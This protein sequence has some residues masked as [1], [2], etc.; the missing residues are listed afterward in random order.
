MAEF[1]DKV[2]AAFD[3]EFERTRPRPGLRRRVI[4]NAVATPRTQQGLRAW[5]TP[6]RLATL[7]AAAVLVLVI[8]TGVRLATQ[9]PPIAKT[10]PTPSAAQLAFG[11]LPPPGLHPPNGLGGGGGGA[12]T[13]V[14]YFGPATLTWSGQ[15]PTVPSSAP[16]YRFGLPTIADE[17]AF[18][19]RLGA[20]LLSAASGKGPRSYQRPDGYT[21]DIGDDAVAGELT[22]VMNRE[23]GAKPRQPLTEAA[24]RAAA[25]AELTRLGLTPSWNLT[26]QISQ[27]TP[28]GQSAPIFVVQYQRLIQVST[29]VTA[30]EVDGDGD[31]A[32][33]QVM[34]DPGGRVIR[35]A[36][37]LRLAE[38][39]AAYPLRAPSTVVP[40]AVTATPATP[41]TNGGSPVPAVTLTKA[42]LVYTVAS[43]NGSGFLEPA[44]L[45]T[46]TFDQGGYPYEKRVLIPAVAPGAIR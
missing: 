32:G 46:G 40:A 28:L 21:L 6:P 35:I 45:F 42:T 5:L 25:D 13:L 24:A 31:P 7:A 20:K 22:F 23:P 11:K 10:S 16:V 2:K 12:P 8:G 9:A 15:L 18:A 41:V 43:A 37:A 19:S 39:P 3:A 34:V 27:V 4:A 14:P 17:D 30:G 36:G 33:I 26:V 1:E 29:T 38:Q 44:Y